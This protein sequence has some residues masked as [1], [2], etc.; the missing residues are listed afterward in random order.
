MCNKN[1]WHHLIGPVISILTSIFFTLAHLQGENGLEHVDGV[2]GRLCI[3]HAF[4]CISV[5]SLVCFI[6]SA[7]VNKD[8][9]EIQR[10]QQTRKMLD[11]SW[12][13]ETSFDWI[14]ENMISQNGL[15]WSV[16][17][18]HGGLP[19]TGSEDQRLVGRAW[20]PVKPDPG[21]PQEHRRTSKN[22]LKATAC[23]STKA[24]QQPSTTKKWDKMIL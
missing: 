15:H 10:P 17:T 13:R 5:R 18:V 9:S 24:K 8:L 21:T 6:R 16:A 1:P 2:V 4:V 3:F 20:L 23:H 14:G 12:C 19:Q 22:D 7:A 11:T